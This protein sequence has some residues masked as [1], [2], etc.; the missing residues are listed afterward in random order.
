MKGILINMIGYDVLYNE[1]DLVG[2][3]HTDND[4]LF[5]I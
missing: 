2:R 3:V 4:G 1:A 5:F